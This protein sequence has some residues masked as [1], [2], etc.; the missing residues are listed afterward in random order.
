[1]SQKS[2]EYYIP[3]MARV[4][5]VCC[6]VLGGVLLWTISDTWGSPWVV[7]SILGG[8]GFIAAPCLGILLAYRD[9][10]QGR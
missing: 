6:L 8:I 3:T 2:G 9:F 1:M 10:R 4:L 7:I 5:L